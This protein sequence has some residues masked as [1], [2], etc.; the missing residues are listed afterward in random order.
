MKKQ[1]IKVLAILA[2]AGGFS[3]GCQLLKDVTYD[4]T[5]DPLEMHGDSVAV[6]VE[7]TFPEKGIHKKAAAE[8]TPMI[9]STA[10]KSVRVQGEKA[11]G[12]GEAI[13]YKAGGKVTYKDVVPYN[14]EMEATDM[15]VTGKIYKGE[16]EKG[17]IEPTKIADAT[18]IT[19]FLV[20]KDFKVVYAQ[21]NFQRVTEETQLTVINFDKGR[22]NVKSSEMRDEDVEAYEEF[23]ADA[24]TN[25]KVEVKKVNVVGYAS[26]E[27]E[28]DKNSGLSDD[29]AAAG[30][31]V[32]MKVAKK[33]KH[34]GGQD[35]ANYAKSGSGEDFD[36]FRRELMADDK[37]DESDKQLVLRILDT[38]KDPAVREQKMRDLGKS[39]TYLDKNIF[40]LLRRAEINTVYDLTGW[41]DEELKNHSVN[42]PDT[43]TVEELL[44]CATLYTDLNEKL[45]VYEIAEKNFPDDYRTSNNVGAVL[46]EMNKVSDAKAKFE[47]A[48][49]VED[50]A[51][52]KNNLGAVAGVE[53]D[54]EKAMDLLNQA[55]G[56]GSEVDYNK[57]ILDVQNGDYADAVSHFGSEASFNL[58]LA[59]LLND[60]ASGAE[61]TVNNSPD[62]DSAQGAY[63]KA[64]AAARQDNLAGIVSNLKNAI[65]KDGAFKAKAAKDREFIKYMENAEFTAIVK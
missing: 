63:L 62:A 57:G 29:R 65:A 33:A 42:N 46:Y 22:S 21:D 50:N 58:A 18:I 55:G 14:A 8:I 7:I 9:G 28:V 2:V 60:N 10:L 16:K 39:F 59:Q 44:F 53:G 54:R 11:T 15:M 1:T 41:S 31:D 49:G 45:R 38:E 26:P 25:E 17:E 19:P 40:P 52:S 34:E 56:A 13:Q 64:I 43:L 32:S 47:K 37:M 3:T 20:N 48:N 5:P 24:Q 61:G 23:L 36:G 12:N 30:A 4:V 6:T 35:E 27:G 51:I